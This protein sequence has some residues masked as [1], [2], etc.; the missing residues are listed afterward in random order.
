M[1][2][3]CFRVFSHTEL[4]YFTTFSMFKSHMVYLLVCMG[5]AIVTNMK[6]K[7]YSFLDHRKT[8]FDTDF[9][10]FCQS[11]LELNVSFILKT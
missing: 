7:Q 11:T 6:K 3:D 1:I 10:Q 2:I 9:E 8:T 4:I 5:Q